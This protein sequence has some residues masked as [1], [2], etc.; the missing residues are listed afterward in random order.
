MFINTAEKAYNRDRQGSAGL[1][2]KLANNNW[3]QA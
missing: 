3:I 1:Q 2:K